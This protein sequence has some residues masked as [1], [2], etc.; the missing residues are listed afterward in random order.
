[1]TPAV[2]A[3]VF[4]ENCYRMGWLSMLNQ[5]SN[6]ILTGYQTRRTLHRVNTAD[7]VQ[8]INNQQMYR[9]RQTP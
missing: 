2:G 1:M 3:I 9:H 8:G 4:I 7:Q 6:R 5:L